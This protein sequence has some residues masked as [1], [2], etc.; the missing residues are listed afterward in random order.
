MAHLVRLKVGGAWFAHMF[1]PGNIEHFVC[2]EGLPEGAELKSVYHD[3]R[4]FDV[5]YMVYEHESL[6]E[7]KS[8]EII[9][10]R[11]I[12]FETIHDK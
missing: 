9:P 2:I 8:G 12:V 6:P 3:E 5:F 10:I 7:V 1:T 4:M 11:D